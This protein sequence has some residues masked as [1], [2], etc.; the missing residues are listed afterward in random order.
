MQT[1]SLPPWE[2]G[3]DHEASSWSHVTEIIP[4]PTPP[5]R[6]GLA[7]EHKID[8]RTPPSALFHEF[9]C[10]DSKSRYGIC[11]KKNTDKGC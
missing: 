1:Y 9:C 3:F 2:V 5:R 8:T 7:L 11:F 6:D 10:T 4:S